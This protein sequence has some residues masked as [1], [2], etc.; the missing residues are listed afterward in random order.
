MKPKRILVVS[1][2]HGHL[3]NDEAAAAVLKFREEYK[4]HT[5]LHLGDAIDAGCFM[6]SNVRTGEGDPIDRDLQRGIEFVE[7]LSPT[8]LFMGNHEDRLWRLRHESRNEFVT[9]AA[10]RVIKSIEQLA[11]ACK[12]EMVPYAGTFDPNSWRT[13]GGTAFGHGFMY[14]EQ[15]AR[16]HAEMLGMPVVIGHVHKLLR[17]PGRAIG[18]PEGIAVGCLCDIPSMAYAKTKR[19]TSAWDHG[20]AWGEYGENWCRLYLER[21]SK[22]KRPNI[23]AGK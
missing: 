9:Y 17:Q 11:K 13:Y 15:A 21:I 23:P 1:C 22:W 16:D 7:N 19:Q 5:V 18:A 2:S 3:I 14:N 20:Y 8:T 10:D 12:A 6:A 4:P